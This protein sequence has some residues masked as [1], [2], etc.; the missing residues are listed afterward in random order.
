MSLYWCFWTGSMAEHLMLNTAVRENA[1]LM[2]GETNGDQQLLGLW[3]GWLASLRKQHHAS[4][5]FLRNAHMPGIYHLFMTVRR[6]QLPRTINESMKCMGS[7]TINSGKQRRL[8]TCQILGT[9]YHSGREHIYHFRNSLR[10]IATRIILLQNGC[11]IL[12]DDWTS[13]ITIGR[14]CFY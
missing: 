6:L 12:M 5:V 10:V 14:D 11:P 8:S 2:W 3:R 13:L 4:K 7:E 9:G 1:L